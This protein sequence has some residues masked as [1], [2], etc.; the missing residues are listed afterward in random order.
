MAL[1]IPR[2]SVP[3]RSEHIFFKS[4]AV[5]H[6]IHLCFGQ[7]LL[8]LTCNFSYRHTSLVCSICKAW[9]LSLID[10]L[11][12]KGW[13]GYDHNPD[14]CCHVQVGQ[15]LDYH[16]IK[17]KFY[18]F[19]CSK[20]GPTEHA[21][22]FLRLLPWYLDGQLV[23]AQYILKVLFSVLLGWLPSLRLRLHVWVP[24]GHNM[25]TE[26]GR[27]LQRRG[28]NF[29]STSVSI[30]LYHVLVTQPDVSMLFS[31]PLK[32]WGPGFHSSRRFIT[33]TFV[34]NFLTIFSSKCQF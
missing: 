11:T 18:W 24:C 14:H 6:L 22:C 5:L 19:L 2:T 26:G 28:G 13:D 32:I 29:R 20:W 30:R 21:S 7:N 33:M 25:F 3:G 17:W 9:R 10:E 15:P 1:F 23:V 8:G 31:R 4:S 34:G 16:C 27:A 12:S